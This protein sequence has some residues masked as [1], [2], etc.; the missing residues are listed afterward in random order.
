MAGNRYRL[1]FTLSDGTTK[2]VEFTAPQGVQGVSPTINVSKSGKVTTLTITD[3]NGTKTA[4]IN[5]GVDGVDGSSGTSAGEYELLGTSPQKIQDAGTVKLACSEESSYQVQSDTVVD[6]DILNGSVAS[7]SVIKEEGV[8]KL[9]YNSSASA[10]Y[11]TYAE[12]TVDGL[13]VGTSY[14]FVFDA[15]GLIYD[16]TDTG[17]TAGHWILYDGSGAILLSREAYDNNIKQVRSFTAT[18]ETVKLRWYPANNSIFKAFSTAAIARVNQ[19][20]INRSGTSTHT[21]VYNKSGVI[22]SG[23]ALVPNVPA[24]VTVSASHSCTVYWTAA[25]EEA[26][27]TRHSGKVCVCFGDSITGSMTAPYDYPSVLAEKTGMKVI[28]AGF[29]GCRMSDT[30]PTAAY[31]AFSMVKLAEAVATGDWTLQENQVGSLSASTNSTEHLAA[32]KA[33]DWAN[34]DFITIA[35]GTNEINSQVTIDDSGNSTNTKTFLGALRYSLTKILMA[36]P[37]IK[38]LLLTPIYR[39]W[40]DES[41]D[42]D[43]KTFGGQKFTTWGDGLLTVA[44][45]FKIPAVDLYRTLGFNSITRSYYFPTNDG[46]H[47]NTKGL[48][49][50]GEKIAAKLLSEY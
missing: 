42:S 47:P 28:N 30:H 50:I 18:T 14:N 10:W 7:G 4:T 38:V 32:L 33:V 8:Y 39:Y 44:E 43:S 12:M 45:E 23:V 15:A 20:Y 29:G 27:K 16:D 22:D 35:Y 49:A 24:G 3:A 9:S 26:S 1:K 34:V 41:V 6:F 17:E 37:Q 19:I 13:T 25:T 11:S 36:Y 48:A 2:K 5:D 31:T 46:T 21:K 40:N